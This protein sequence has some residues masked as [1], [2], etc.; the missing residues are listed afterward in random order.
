LVSFIDVLPQSALSNV[1]AATAGVEVFLDDK[2]QG[3]RLVTRNIDQTFI[4]DLTQTKVLK[5]VVDCAN[6][7]AAWDWVNIGIK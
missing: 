5:I 1:E 3:R 4:L 7:T 2:S 6:G